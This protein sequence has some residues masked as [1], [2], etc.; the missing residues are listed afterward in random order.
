MIV[1]NT[2]YWKIGQEGGN[3]LP[4]KL[5]RGNQTPVDNS[6]PDGQTTETRIPLPVTQVAAPQVFDEFDFAQPPPQGLFVNLSFFLSFSYCFTSIHSILS[7]FARLQKMGPQRNSRV[8]SID[9]PIGGRPTN[10][11]WRP[12]TLEPKE[13]K[14]FIYFV[15]NWK[16]N[17]LKKNEKCFLEIWKKELELSKN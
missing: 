1:L 5:T 16:W 14:E 4:E 7:P 6:M 11:H 10:C 17:K 2:F 8:L 3:E 12:L 9:G 15:L 13:F